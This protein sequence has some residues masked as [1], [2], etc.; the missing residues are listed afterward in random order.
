[1]E[2]LSILVIVAGV[3]L[4]LIVAIIWSKRKSQKNQEEVVQGESIPPGG[5]EVLAEAMVTGD[6]SQAIRNQEARGQGSFVGSNTLPTDMSP[7]AQKVLKRAGVK[8]L[9]VV[10][11]DPF[12]Q[13]VK[14]PKGWKKEKTSHSMHSDL[15]DEKVKVK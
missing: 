11:N 10:P 7:K 6:T 1:M 5:L 12:F 2:N 3:T 14:L 9:G 15:V 4:A 13:N 8:F